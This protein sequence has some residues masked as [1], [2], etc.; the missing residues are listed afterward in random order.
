MVEPYKKWGLRYRME[1]RLII[2]EVFA[3][4]RNVSFSWIVDTRMAPLMLLG[5]CGRHNIGFGSYDGLSFLLF[6]GCFGIGFA[7][8]KMEA[9]AGFTEVISIGFMIEFDIIFVS[10]WFLLLI[11]ILLGCL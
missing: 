7:Q 6:V 9:T 1:W 3:N 4:Y 10:P 8:G 2:N 5:D 11:H